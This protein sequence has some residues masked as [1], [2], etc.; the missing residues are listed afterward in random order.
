MRC[1]LR[2]PKHAS[3][4]VMDRASAAYQGQSQ[5]VAVGLRHTATCKQIS[6][7]SV[8]AWAKPPAR[9]PTIRSD[10]NTI[11]PWGTDC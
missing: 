1:T 3:N 10:S 7:W 11:A 8:N 6:Q 9:S 5:A 2:E 4:W